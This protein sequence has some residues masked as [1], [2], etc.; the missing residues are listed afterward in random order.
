[1]LHLWEHL[2]SHNCR[3]SDDICVIYAALTTGR[4]CYIVSNDHMS[5]NASML[6]P[7]EAKLFATW[8]SSRQITVQPT[9]V[10]LLV[11]YFHKAFFPVWHYVLIRINNFGP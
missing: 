2:T 6:G 9:T 7:Q 3:I 10:H 8:Q 11:D 4:D 1:M 5:D